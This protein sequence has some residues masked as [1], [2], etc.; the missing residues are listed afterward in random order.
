MPHWKYSRS[1]CRQPKSTTRATSRSDGRTDVRTTSPH[2]DLVQS[3]PHS[4]GVNG[5][6]MSTCR[7]TSDV[8]GRKVTF[9]PVRKTTCLDLMSCVNA[10][11]AA[12]IAVGRQTGQCL[13]DVWHDVKWWKYE[14]RCFKTC[15]CRWP[16]I[17]N[18]IGQPIW[19]S[20]VVWSTRRRDCQRHAWMT[21]VTRV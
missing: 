1:M 6:I 14:P 10:P 17:S 8:S 7:I 3:I 12:P 13:L 16:Y 15:T 9:T 21:L 4:F 5:A 19:T 2:M 11:I 20:V 18:T